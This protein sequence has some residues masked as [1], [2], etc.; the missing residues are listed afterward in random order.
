MADQYIAP[1]G[2]PVSTP[3]DTTAAPVKMTRS[4]VG[5]MAYQA[6]KKKMADDPQYAASTKAAITEG[7]DAA[8][9][10]AYRILARE[11]LALNSTEVR[12]RWYTIKT[13]VKETGWDEKR[14]SNYLFNHR[15][16]FAKKARVSRSLLPHKKIPAQAQPSLGRAGALP[17]APAAPEIFAPSAPAIGKRKSITEWRFSRD[18]LLQLALQHVG[19]YGDA[20]WTD[21][22]VV[23]LVE[24][25]Q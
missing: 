14:C 24:D 20:T 2:R 4:E 9:A 10:K 17:L 15:I 5:R 16:D 1:P 23:V 25:E 12:G 18:D 21:D 19:G 7:M 22:G 11:C 8:Y 3:P 6:H 13:L